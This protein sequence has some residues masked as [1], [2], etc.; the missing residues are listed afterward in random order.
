MSPILGGIGGVSV[1]GFGH[2]PNLYFSSF[3][4]IATTTVGAGGA[5]SITFSSI[6]STYTH[7]QIRAL[8]RSAGPN[9]G[10]NT[11]IYVNG[12]SAATNYAW[13]ALRGDGATVVSGG[14]TNAYIVANVGTTNTANVFSGLIIDILDYTNTNKNKTVRTLYGFDANG[15]GYIGLNSVLVPTTSTISQIDIFMDYNFTQYSS[16]ALYGIKVA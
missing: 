9:N 15:S 13:H 3:D 2:F 4:S 8:A 11:K 16:F 10:E 12:S 14:Q 7:L 1:R 5:S 6:P